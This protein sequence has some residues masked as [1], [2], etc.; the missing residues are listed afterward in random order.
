VAAVSGKNYSSFFSVFASISVSAV[1]SSIGVGGV[2]FI[3]L[4]PIQVPTPKMA[5]NAIRTGMAISQNC[6][7]ACVV[8]IPM[9]ISH[10]G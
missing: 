6:I 9:E 4:Q 5:M 7:S 3:I 1:F 8:C 2:V 10:C